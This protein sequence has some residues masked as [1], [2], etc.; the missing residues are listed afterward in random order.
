[1]LTAAA[2]TYQLANKSID[3]VRRTYLRDLT[4][5]EDPGARD[6]LDR[7]IKGGCLN[8]T[9][10]A[11]DFLL[12]YPPLL[13]REP[14]LGEWAG[15]MALLRIGFG[16]E[17]AF[18]EADKGA[19]YESVV[20]ARMALEQCCWARSIRNLDALEQIL[21]MSVRHCVTISTREI[22]S[23][24]RL[25]GWMSNHAHWNHRAQLKSLTMM[26][27]YSSV[28]LASAEFKAIAYCSILITTD[29]YLKTVNQ[30]IQS[31]RQRNLTDARRRWRSVVRRFKPGYWLRTITKHLPESAD[32]AELNDIYLKTSSRSAW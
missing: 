30:I 21:G 19:L 22:P 16:L 15:D 18:A 31:Y 4:Y 13:R 9:R 20:I 3:G 14:L 10:A 6:R 23:I 32:A 5:D 17:R 29:V 28:M 1:M 27:G 8:I 26:G 25:Y 2:V 12:E 11:G 24:G 7:A